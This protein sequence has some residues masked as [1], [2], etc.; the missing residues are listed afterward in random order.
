VPS[1]VPTF[2]VPNS[3]INV[4]LMGLDE[5]AGGNGSQ[6]TDTM[7]VVSIDQELQ[8]ASLLSIPRDLYVY[9]PGWTMNRINTALEYGERAG[10]PGGGVGLLKDTI[11]YNFGVPINYYA[12][13]DFTGFQTVVDAIGGI[14][15]P[16]TCELTDW[17]LKAPDLDPQVEDNWE[18][19]TMPPGVQLMDGETALWYVRSRTSGSADWGRSLRQQQVLHAMLNQGVDVGL[20]A[21]APQLWNAYRDTVET[22]MDI[23]RM[24]QLATVAQ[25]VRA[26]GVQHLYL[27]GKT[28]SWAV[29]NS[30]A[31]VQLPIWAGDNM[32]RDTFRR[33]LLPPALTRVTRSPIT[34][35]IVNASGSAITG[36]L[37]AE[38]FAR[39]GFLPIL[40]ENTLPVRDATTVTYFA[41]N[42]KSSYDWLLAWVAGISRERIVLDPDT[43]SE[44]SY[45]VVVGRNYDTCLNELFAPQSFLPDED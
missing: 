18:L 20:V 15:V 29:P 19:V 32:M 41:P 9:I 23:G 25:G 45:Q 42:F 35:E 31:A 17:R 39:H 44:I 5:A 36:T 6:R 2:E 26:N 24:L 33:L 34:V 12:R 37:A 8:T 38:N 3:T 16:V 11:L 7:I 14:E 1:I 13:V 22:D 21:Q 27:A 40:S 28:A 43:V 10:Y 30:G 4:L